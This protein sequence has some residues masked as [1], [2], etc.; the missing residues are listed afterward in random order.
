MSA[1]VRQADTRGVENELVSI[2]LDAQLVGIPVAQ[3]QDILGPQRITAV[4][5]AAAE[6]AG[7]L[8][9]RGRIVTAIDLRVRLGMRPRAAD[10]DSMSV[11]VEHKG[12]LYSLLID[13]VGEVLE[14]PLDRFEADTGALSPAWREL[15]SGVFRLEQRLLVVLDVGRVLQI[16]AGDAARPGER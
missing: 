3:V 9:L 13:R 15:A 4:P 1:P 7:M 14:A 12:E 8:N 11:V 2:W 16:A 6:I 5:R 10:A